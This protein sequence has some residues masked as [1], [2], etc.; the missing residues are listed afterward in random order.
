MR[1]FLAGLAAGLVIGSAGVAAAAA[2]LVGR[3]GYLKGYSVFIKG[4]KACEDPYVWM[5]NT[6]QID[7]E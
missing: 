1:K 2:D 6:K 5:G 3:S 4:E 7:C